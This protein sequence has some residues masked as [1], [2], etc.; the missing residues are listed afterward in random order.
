MMVLHT[1]GRLWPIKRLISCDYVRLIETLLMDMVLVT[2]IGQH[3]LNVGPSL[4]VL[5]DKISPSI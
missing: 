4:S 2:Y 3:W 1:Y 5:A